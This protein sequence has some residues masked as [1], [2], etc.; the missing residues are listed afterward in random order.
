MM[1]II[2]PCLD[3]PARMRT[4]LT[5]DVCGFPAD[6]AVVTGAGPARRDAVWAKVGR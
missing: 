2:P 6:V 4:R 3:V 5:C 1:G